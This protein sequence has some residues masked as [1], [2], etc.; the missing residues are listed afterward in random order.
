MVTIVHYRECPDDEKVEKT[1]LHA[2][3]HFFLHRHLSPSYKA[4]VA[5]PQQLQHHDSQMAV[6][7]GRSGDGDNDMYFDEV[8]GQFFVSSISPS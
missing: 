3:V 7:N 2:I 6:D 1:H 4:P 8:G 5:A